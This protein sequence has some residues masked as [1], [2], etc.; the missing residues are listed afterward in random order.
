MNYH[1]CRG[2][3]IHVGFEGR[4]GAVTLAWR[5]FTLHLGVRLEHWEFGYGECWYDGPLPYLGCG[6]LFLLCWMY[7]LEDSMDPG[8]WP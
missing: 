4:A 5:G 2:L 1:Q 8:M 6:P 7:S 3:Y